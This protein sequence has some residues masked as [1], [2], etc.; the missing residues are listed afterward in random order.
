MLTVTDFGKPLF[1]LYSFLMGFTT[2]SVR[3][4]ATTYHLSDDSGSTGTRTHDPPGYEPDAR[5]F[6]LWIHMAKGTY[7]S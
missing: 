2:A 1:T 6:E 3:L 7:P 5:P 4:Q